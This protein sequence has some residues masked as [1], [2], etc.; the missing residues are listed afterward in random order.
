VVA[1]SAFPLRGVEVRG[2]AELVEA[3]AQETAVAIASRYLGP[4]RGAAFVGS[5][6]DPVIVRLAP[7]DLRAWDFTD[8]R[9]AM[10]G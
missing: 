7:G 1:E 8:E 5:A 2:R 4:D 3:G 9:E 6:G 10:L